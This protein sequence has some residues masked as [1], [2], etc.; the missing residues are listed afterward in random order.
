MITLAHDADIIERGTVHELSLNAVPLETAALAI[1]ERT[2]AALGVF[3]AKAQ[4]HRRVTIEVELELAEPAIAVEGNS[5]LLTPSI[6][7]HT[8]AEVGHGL[9]GAEPLE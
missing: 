5:R 6:G 3:L 7:G 9:P 8:I 4:A 1:A 2:I